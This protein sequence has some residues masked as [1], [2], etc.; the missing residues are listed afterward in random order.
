M[1]H[2][3]F[4]NTNM[5]LMSV[6][7]AVITLLSVSQVKDAIVFFKKRYDNYEIFLSE[8][9]DC[10]LTEKPKT[11]VLYQKDLCIDVKERL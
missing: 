5:L 8:T 6:A 1:M 11:A 4:V 2:S 7:V 3:I 10:H 9:V